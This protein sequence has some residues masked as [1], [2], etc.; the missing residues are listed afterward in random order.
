MEKNKAGFTLVEAL[1]SIFLTVLLIIFVS[2]VF[3]QLQ[4][5][6]QLSENHFNAAILARS[7]IRSTVGRGFSAMSPSSGT[8]SISGTRDGRPFVHAFKYSVSISSLD[9]DKKSVWATVTWSE[10]KAAKQVVLETIV[11]NPN[12]Q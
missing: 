3:P 9:T 4:R 7:L 12:Q 5:G 2:S 8:T 1:I 10:G 11:V 6:I